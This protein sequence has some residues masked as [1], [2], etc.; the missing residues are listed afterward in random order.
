MKKFFSCVVVTI[1][2]LLSSWVWVSPASADI[3]GYRSKVEKE[4]EVEYSEIFSK[5]YMSIPEYLEDK[6][7]SMCEIE[8][9]NYQRQRYSQKT[10]K[11]EGVCEF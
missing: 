7:K 6:I 8:G 11:I 2:F 5:F 3:S 9:G 1:L 10:E 4:V